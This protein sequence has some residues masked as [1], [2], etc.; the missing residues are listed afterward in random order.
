MVSENKADPGN[1]RRKGSLT[2]VGLGPGAA[3]HLSL[4]TLK[5]LEERFVILRTEVHPTVTELKRRGISYLSCD[6]WYEKEATFEEVYDKIS[7]FVIEQ[8]ENKE[9]VYAVPGSPLVAERTVTLLREKAKRSNVPLVIKPAMSFLDLAYTELGIDPIDGLRI[10]DARDFSALAD[11]GQYPLMVTQVFNQMVASDM[12]LT[13]MDILPD[14]TEVCFLRNLGL[15]DEECRKIPLFELDRQPVIDHLT[16]VFI[17]RQPEEVLHSMLQNLKDDGDSDGYWKRFPLLQH[18]T[19]FDVRPLADVMQVLREPG[20]CPWDREQDFDTIRANLIEECYEFLEAVDDKDTYGMAEELGDILMQVVFHAR[21]A[22]EKGMFTLQDVID[23]VTDKLIERH[24]HVFGTV[25]VAD[26]DEVLTNWEAIKLQ[27]KPER[28]RVLDGIYKGLPSLLRAHKIQK[29]VA[30]VGFDWTETEDVK[31]K[32]LEEWKEFNEAVG[33]QNQDEMEKELGDL[34]FSMVNFAR[35][36]GLE[37]ETAL[38]R[39]NNRFV[40]RFEHVENRVKDSGKDWKEYSLDEL[41]RFWDEAK[42]SEKESE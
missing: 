4:E 32:V 20:G 12:K 26:S 6:A 28:E 10:I 22:E 2:I 1:K 16:S 27:E 7:S 38:N 25:K 5:L 15:E 11:A 40:T 39:C 23:N 17:P 37:S 13:L 35:H 31:K 42:E 29:R 8:A 30:K 19:Q 9:V 21:M 3:G 14:E 18:K 34:C 33:L 41:D 36:L 24:P